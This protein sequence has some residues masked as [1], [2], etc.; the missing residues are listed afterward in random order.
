MT[1][2][3][4][5]AGLALLGGGGTKFGLWY[6][7]IKPPRLGWFYIFTYYYLVTLMVSLCSASGAQTVT[8]PLASLAMW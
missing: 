6:G 7:H 4:R 5:F 3:F 2:T 8:L 1:I